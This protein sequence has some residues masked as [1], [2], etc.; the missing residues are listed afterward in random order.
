[1]KNQGK[2]N[3][4]EIRYNRI[5][6]RPTGNPYPL[7]PI[8]FFPKFFLDYCFNPIRFAHLQYIRF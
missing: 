8:I 2:I 3:I 6:E 1:M 5:L 4:Q 7:S